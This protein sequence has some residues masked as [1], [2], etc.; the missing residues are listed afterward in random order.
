MGFSVHEEGRGGVLYVVKD[1]LTPE[2]KRLVKLSYSGNM[3][4]E[5]AFLAALRAIGTPTT[6]A[7][8]RDTEGAAPKE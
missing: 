3:N 6:T 5:E 8:V 1:E 2:Q 4:S 7:V